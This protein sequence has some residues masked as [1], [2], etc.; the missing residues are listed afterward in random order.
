MLL[1]I[2]PDCCITDVGEKYGS[3][4]RGDAGASTWVRLHDQNFV[5]C[6]PQLFQR[7]TT[8]ATAL[9]VCNSWRGIGCAN[10]SRIKF[11]PALVNARDRR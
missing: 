1:P 6:Q 3:L 7:G 4:W 2:G 10:G 5:V 8:S 11:Y 9:C